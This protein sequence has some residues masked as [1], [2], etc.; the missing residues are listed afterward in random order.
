M[1]LL[2]GMS[3]KSGKFGVLPDAPEEEFCADALKDETLC[4]TCKY[5]SVD[6]CGIPSC[7]GNEYQEKEDE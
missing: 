7:C 5:Y 1:G 4:D 6:R 3:A 2:I